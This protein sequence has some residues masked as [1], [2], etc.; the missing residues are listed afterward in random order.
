MKT[1]QQFL[2]LNLILALGVAA[3]AWKVITNWQRFEATHTVEAVQPDA[4]AFDVASVR[5]SQPEATAGSWDEIAI[6]NPFSFDRSDIAYT[7]EAGTAEIR[8]KPL[9]LGTMSL[10]GDPMAMLAP[11]DARNARSYLPT[12]IGET[13]DG[14]ELVEIG[15][16]SV[17]VESNSVRT[18]VIMNDP[19]A[20][21]PRETA[22]A[23]RPAPRANEPVVVS[24]EAARPPQTAGTSAAVSPPNPPSQGG[25][26]GARRVE[27]G[28]AV[29]DGMREVRTPWGTFQVPVR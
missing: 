14:W 25:V 29:P 18:T 20:V 28:S 9:L 23:T 22:R 5:E 6:M 13:V 26:A 21:I 8:D 11:A 15:S 1:W 7:P 16:K 3:G 10:G 12:R 4:D 19:S 17:V 24:S 2:V 27:P